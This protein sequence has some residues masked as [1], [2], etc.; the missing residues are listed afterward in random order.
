[1][2]IHLFTA[3]LL[4]LLLDSAPVPM[5]EESPGKFRVALGVGAAAFESKTFS[6]SGSLI[7][8]TPVKMQG[9]G[10]LFEYRG[11]SLRVTAWGGTVDSDTG[12]LFREDYEGG[13]AGIQIA[14]DAGAF[15]IGAGGV[16]IGGDDGFL[17]PSFYLRGGHLDGA[18]FRFDIFPPTETFTAWSWARLGIGVNRTGEGIGYYLGVG[19]MPYTYI[20]QFEPRFLGELEVPVGNKVELFFRGQLGP[21]EHEAQWGFGTGIAL[22]LEDDR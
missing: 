10:G 12:N 8:A 22:R 11:P 3:P 1:V 9:I 15:G 5:V 18:H 20:D 7:N 4:I 16:I 17:A 6:C 2:K 21:G 14:E 19:I 13:Y